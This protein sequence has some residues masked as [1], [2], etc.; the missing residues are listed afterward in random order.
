MKP[1][2]Q[3]PV[4]FIAAGFLFTPGT[5]AASQVSTSGCTVRAAHNA[6]LGSSN[7][8]E[9]STIFSGERLAT[10][11]AGEV[12]LQCGSIRLGLKEN[13]SIRTFQAGTKTIVELEH[14]TV[15]YATSG[16]SEDLV[17]YTL[18]IRIVPMTSQPAS[19]QVS[20]PSHC[21]ATV[22]PIKSSATVTSG[23]ETKNIEE[24]KSY[25]VRAEEGVDYRDDWKPVLSDYPELPRD[26]DYHRSHGHIA[27]AP[28]FLNRGGKPPMQALGSGHF[29]EIAIAVV[30][31][32]TG[33]GIHKVLESP[34]RP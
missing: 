27:C 17:L 20:S 6:T 15:A 13:S 24:S 29:R 28:A 18:D 26:T 23:K 19:G 33:V 16:Q 4:A 25:E 5:A 10:G 7:V 34:D 3:F 1:L 32:G 9:G 31:I 12:L 21:E 30:G 2:I 11:S 8:S 14:G 22:S